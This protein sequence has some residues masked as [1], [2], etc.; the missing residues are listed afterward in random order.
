MEISK[1]EDI[2]NL[3]TRL[4]LYGFDTSISEIKKW[5]KRTNLITFKLSEMSYKYLT[6]AQIT[7]ILLNSRGTLKLVVFDN[8]Y[9]AFINKNDEPSSIPYLYTKYTDVQSLFEIVEEQKWAMIDH[10]AWGTQIVCVT[11]VTSKEKAKEF[12]ETYK[13]LHDIARSNYSIREVNRND[14]LH[15]DGRVTLQDL[16]EHRDK[17]KNIIRTF[18]WLEATERQKRKEAIKKN[19]ILSK[20]R[21]KLTVKGLDNHTYV[22]RLSEEIEKEHFVPLVYLHRYQRNTNLLNHYKQNTLWEE[23]WDIL[24]YKIISEMKQGELGISVDKKKEAVISWKEL[25]TTKCI[26]T[27]YY[28][29]GCR[30]GFRRIPILLKQYFF[31]GVPL[32]T[33]GKTKSGKKRKR[34]IVFL[35]PEEKRLL[36]EGIKGSIT[37]LEGTVP[38]YL[39]VEKEDSKWYLTLSGEKIYIK[40]GLG[41]IRKI[42]TI[43]SDYSIYR[44]KYSAEALYTVLIEACGEE[45]A[46]ELITAIK[47]MGKLLNA[48]K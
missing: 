48:I 20:D 15:H 9:V 1:L 34:R 45:K 44:G 12:L 14:T 2:R 47:E 26:R 5:I 32:K 19:L 25:R 29:N 28:L 8:G 33:K 17:L 7:K 6:F 27:D 16:K 41:V 39:G 13:E 21:K 30:T 31:Q 10:N 11:D 38:V 3:E 36:E 42:K 35:S 46:L 4:K 23:V 37:D 43:V 40:G 24:S 18:K 22:I